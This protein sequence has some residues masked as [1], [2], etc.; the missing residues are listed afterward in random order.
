MM[1]QDLLLV[2]DG[3]EATPCNDQDEMHDL[4]LHRDFSASA[5]LLPAAGRRL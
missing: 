5:L 3:E 4:R 2:V 1:A